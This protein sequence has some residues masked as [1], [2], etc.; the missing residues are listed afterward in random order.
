MN[1]GIEAI[2]SESINLIKLHFT[3]CACLRQTALFWAFPAAPRSLFFEQADCKV[4]L[5]AFG[6]Y[7]EIVYSDV[8]S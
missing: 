1:H 3:L 8:T 5:E 7:Y 4:P 2:L 6:L